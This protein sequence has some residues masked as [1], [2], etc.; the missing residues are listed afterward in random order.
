MK[1]LLLRLIAR[2]SPQARLLILSLSAL[3]ALQSCG[4]LIKP[5]DQSATGHHS[6]DGTSNSLPVNDPPTATTDTTEQPKGYATFS[7]DT[8]YA[9]LVA[10]LA[11]TRGQYDLTLN[12]YLAEAVRTQD[13]GVIARAARLAQYFRRQTQALAM[14]QLWLSKAPDNLEA[15]TLVANAHIALRQPVKALEYAEVIL[16]RLDPQ[17]EGAQRRAALVETIAS[18]SREAATLTRE[19]LIDRYQQ[20]SRHYPDYPALP[21]GLSILQQDGGDTAT[22]YQVIQQVL[23]ENSDYM[24]A[25]LQEIRL[26]RASEQTDKALAKLNRQLTR[27]PDNQRLRLIYARLLSEVDLQASYEEFTRL[28]QQ[29][30]RQLDITFSRA[31]VAMELQKRA[32]AEELLVELLALR[33]RPDTIHFYLG[34]LAELDQRPRKALSHYLSVS[35]GEQYVTAHSRAARIMAGQGSIEQAREYFV[36]LREQSPEQKPQLYAA[37]AE[38]L[39]DLGHG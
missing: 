19:I 2:L 1:L 15:N 27:Q 3:I 32:L 5:P 18:H 26:L 24:P 14:G 10:E 12:N 33:Y 29:A 8:L 9:L 28:S 7:T 25:I 4:T 38:V 23:A 21:V 35:G 13:T 6:A 39:G 22:A 31:L 34:S 11:A 20:L 37:E 36:T 17:E 30:P 16:A